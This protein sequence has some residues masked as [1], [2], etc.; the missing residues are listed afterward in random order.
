MPN[1]QHLYVC[2]ASARWLAQSARRAGLSPIALDLFGDWDTRQCC[3]S[4]TQSSFEHLTSYLPAGS[5]WQLLIGGGLESNLSSFLPWADSSVWKNSSLNS[6]RRA[7]DPFHWTPELQSDLEHVAQVQS[8]LESTDDPGSWLLKSSQSTGGLKIR[9]ADQPHPDQWQDIYFQQR[10]PGRPI[11][12]LHVR[13]D[14]HLTT[15]GSFLQLVGQP[16]FPV[17]DSHSDRKLEGDPSTIYAPPVFGTAPFVFCGAIGPILPTEHICTIERVARRLGSLCDLQ[18]VFGIDWIAND[19]QIVPIEINP[20]ITSTAELWE[21]ST[22]GNIVQTQLNALAGKPIKAPPAKR[23]VGKAIQWNPEEPRV[24][25]EPELQR[26][27]GFHRDHWV[28]DLPNASTTIQHGHPVYTVYASSE[29]NHAT[30]ALD[31]RSRLIQRA[32]EL[33]WPQKKEA[34]PDPSAL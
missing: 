28:A 7:R 16:E 5:D 26:L 17:A 21:L 18:G 30:A 1:P 23:I 6:I 27:I 11:S 24:I 25:S 34:S 22:G 20:R 10:I 9:R 32:E 33:R 4:Y 12:S 8:I 14:H 13:Q 3:T 15:L 2:S 29:T 31:V 19:Q